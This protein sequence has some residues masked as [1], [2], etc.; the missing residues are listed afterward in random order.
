MEN[1]CGIIGILPCV[2]II[3]LETGASMTMIACIDMLL[4]RVL[5]EQPRLSISKFRSKE[6]YSA[7]NWSNEMERFGGTRYKI[8]QDAPG[9]KFKFGK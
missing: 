3:S 1:R 9:A 2:V 7:E 4:V 6:V 8:S 5:K